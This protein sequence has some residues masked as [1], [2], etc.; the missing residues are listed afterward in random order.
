MGWV[1]RPPPRETGAARATPFFV[2]PP[3]F[4]FV[5]PGLLTETMEKELCQADFEGMS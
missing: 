5:V 1:S 3:R 4:V 2:G